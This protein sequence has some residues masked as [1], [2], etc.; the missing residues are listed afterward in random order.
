MRARFKPYLVIRLTKPHNASTR[1]QCN[2]GAMKQI[3]P[4]VVS[5]VL[6]FTSMCGSYEE[7]AIVRF[8]D[9]SLLTR[10]GLR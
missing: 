1:I 9:Y 5:G 4:L 10:P 6:Y 2:G 3:D 7:F 8:E